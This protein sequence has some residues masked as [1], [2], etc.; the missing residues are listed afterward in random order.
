MKEPKKEF[1]PEEKVNQVKLL[2]ELSKVTVDIAMVHH[3]N[4]EQKD[5]KVNVPIMVNCG[6]EQL[7]FQMAFAYND[8]EQPKLEVLNQEG[9]GKTDKE[10]KRV[11]QAI[12]FN[13]KLFDFIVEDYFR[14]VGAD[15]TNLAKHVTPQ[16]AIIVI[17]NT[18]SVILFPKSSVVELPELEKLVEGL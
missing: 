4:E 18:A 5:P 14:A 1:K 9:F 8:P 7:M 13:H 16:H 3:N 15:T 12:K 10:V 17:A 11:L 2:R 6:E